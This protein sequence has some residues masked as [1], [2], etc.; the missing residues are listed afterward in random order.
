MRIVVFTQQGCKPCAD[1][2]PHLEAAAGMLKI[3]VEE[4]DVTDNWPL[5]QEY[6]VTYTP[7][8]F[9]LDE[10][11]DAVRLRTTDPKVRVPSALAIKSELELYV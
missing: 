10:H 4:W 9:V 5:C 1:L 7:T 8:A 2:R 3:E 11:I 6:G